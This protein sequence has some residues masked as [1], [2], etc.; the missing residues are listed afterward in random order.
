[1]KKAI[2]L[3]VLAALVIT[4]AAAVAKSTTGPM[5]PKVLYVLHG[6]LSAY[7]AYDAATQTPGSITILVKRA[8]YHN[9]ALHNQ[10]LT[11]PVGANTRII[12]NN[13]VTAIANGD[14]GAVK[15]IAPQRI[16]KADLAAT[17]QSKTARAIVDNGPPPTP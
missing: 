16:P 1:M 17:L 13:G 12:L 9:L 14:S 5:N 10:S 6:P 3:A 8:N 7:T 11:F 15:L 4:P 2:L